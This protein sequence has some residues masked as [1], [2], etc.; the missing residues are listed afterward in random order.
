MKFYIV[1][2]INISMKYLNASIS[3][4]LGLFMYKAMPLYTVST[5]EWMSHVCICFNIQK[6]PVMCHTCTVF[7]VNK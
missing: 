3:I 2:T 6:V 4:V 7:N 1:Y 5:F